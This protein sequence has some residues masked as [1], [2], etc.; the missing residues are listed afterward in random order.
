[1]LQLQN[2]SYAI[3]DNYLIHNAQWIINPKKRVA[4]IGPNGA[5]KTTLF[6][7]IA[8]EIV[9]YGGRIIKPKDYEIGYL[10]QEEL[11]IHKG[12][13]L[14]IALEGHREILDIEEEMDKI[15]KALADTSLSDNK[16]NL[17]RLGILES[18]YKL[19]GGYE[20]ESQTKKILS[21]LGFSESDFH[22]PIAEMS[23]GWRMRAFLARL[24]IQEPDLLLLDE[25]TNHLD[26][27]SL[28]WIESYLKNF[29]GSMVI[30]SHDRFFID[31]LADEIVELERG[32]LTHY[33]GGYKFY[34]QKKE[35]EQDQLI[36]KWEEQKE[37]RARIQRFIDRFRYKNTTASQVQSRIKMLEKMENI[38]LP[39]TAKTIH[40]KI[41]ADMVSYREALKIKNMYFRY[42]D[43]WV[44]HDINLDMY[45]GEK[46]A[47]VG[48]NGAGKTTL[49]RLISG[50][51]QPQKGEIKLGER[52]HVGYYAQ[53]QIDTLNLENTIYTEVEEH[54]ARS[55]HPKLRDILGIFRFTGEEIDKRINVLSGGEKARVSLAKILLSPGNFLIMDEPTNHLDLTSKEALEQALKD[56]DGTLLLISHDRYFLDRL[57]SRVIE[58]KDGRL[59]E[60]EGN[61][62]DYL[63]KRDSIQTSAAD[64]TFKQT[65]ENSGSEARSG[66]Q[67]KTKEQKQKE[68]EA[69][70]AVS[71]K[72]NK[73]QEDIEQI[74]ETIEKL[75]IKI[76]ISSAII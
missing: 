40:F 5:G 67:K 47:L 28:E 3:G 11:I 9:N 76:M 27:E 59:N 44:L 58:L 70:Q 25:P 22:R 73:L 21:G 17:D 72:R 54:A 30:I 15:H 66:R 61:Y 35:L 62:S 1:M 31:R 8:G 12:S 13:V 48:V 4:L 55:F 56:Y 46:V 64:K 20:L 53:H 63:S 42:D 52:V 16:N 43:N 37:E 10:P 36:K 33:A 26:L 24:L 32:K 50:E 69:R 34:K 39:E 23:G 45:R 7:I 6:R 51:L 68:A 60:Y 75:E 49:T 71:K 18:R 14:G 74:E 29:S 38:E 65:K 19:L 57:V 2:I 41:T